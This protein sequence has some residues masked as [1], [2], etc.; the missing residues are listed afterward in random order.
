MRLSALFI[1][2]LG[3]NPVPLP[4]EQAAGVPQATQDADIIMDR[5]RNDPELGDD[6]FN[7]K[8]VEITAYRVDAVDGSTLRMSE[9]G[10][11]LR[12]DGVTKKGVNKGDVLTLV[13]EGDGLRG[14]TEIVFEGCVAR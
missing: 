7:D 10:F 9:R 3:C 5:Y 12:L 8:T 1:V 13:C 14:D 4:R 2:F 11:T 6:L